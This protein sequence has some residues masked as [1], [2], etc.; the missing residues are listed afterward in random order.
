[1]NFWLKQKFSHYLILLILQQKITYLIL[2]K[3]LLFSKNHFFCFQKWKFLG[4]PTRVEFAIFYLFIFFWRFAHVFSLTISTKMCAENFLLF[5]NWKILKKIEKYL[6]STCFKKP[7][8]Q[9]CIITTEQNK[10]KTFLYTFLQT[11]QALQ[12]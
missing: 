5:F 7:V 3:H 8:F 10:R 2:A 11:L 12:R 9:F 1:M 4:A 6:I